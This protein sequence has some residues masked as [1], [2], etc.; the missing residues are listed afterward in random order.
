MRMHLISGRMSDTLPTTQDLIDAAW[1]TAEKILINNT[2]DAYSQN[3]ANRLYAK[4]NC[5]EWRKQRCDAVEVWVTSVWEEY[6][7]CK[8][9]LS[10]GGATSFNTE[11]IGACPYT[12]WQIASDTP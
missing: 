4:Q 2:W 10:T 7:R 3:S 8:Y 1:R 12:I 5:P 9:I 11:A 6:G